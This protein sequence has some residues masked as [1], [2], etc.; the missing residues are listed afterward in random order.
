MRWIMFLYCYEN[1]FEFL[2]FFPNKMR[3]SKQF[4]DW[5]AERSIC[6][7]KLLRQVLQDSETGML[8]RSCVKTGRLKISGEAKN[9]M[10]K[11]QRKPKVLKGGEQRNDKL[12][13]AFPEMTNI[14]T[15][16]PPPP[17]NVHYRKG[18]ARLFA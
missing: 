16:P 14:N 12:W 5:D 2:T 15:L 18:C 9:T 4:Q 10:E 17:I 7:H 6:K 13:F 11:K 3:T 8:V 1:I